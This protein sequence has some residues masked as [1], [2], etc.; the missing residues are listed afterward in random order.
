MIKG[1]EATRKNRAGW[2]R[3]WSY[4][5]QPLCHL[6]E[7]LLLPT[8]GSPAAAWEHSFAAVERQIASSKHFISSHHLPRA[9]CTSVSLLSRHPNS[10]QP[11]KLSSVLLQSPQTAPLSHFIFFLEGHLCANRHWSAHLS[12]Q[13]LYL[14]ITI[15]SIFLIK[16]YL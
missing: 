4:G 3:P 2:F 13:A 1:A 10:C 11:C 7:F 6:A 14:T 12:D 5:N 9:S 15:F 8:S 16:L